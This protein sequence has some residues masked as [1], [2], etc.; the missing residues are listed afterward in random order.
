M[1]EAP[2][3]YWN[4]RAPTYWEEKNREK[5]LQCIKSQPFCAFPKE[6]W[7]MLTSS[8]SDFNEVKVLVPSRIILSRGFCVIQQGR[9]NLG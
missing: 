3:E 4:R 5:S 1:S 9:V 2:E 6:V 7:E 8:F